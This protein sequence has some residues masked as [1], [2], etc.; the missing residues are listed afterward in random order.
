MRTRDYRRKQRAKHI[1]RKEDII[2]SY[3]LDNPPHYYE[4]KDLFENVPKIH[5]V[6]L[7]KEGYWTPYWVVNHRGKLNKGKIHCSCSMCSAKTRNKGTRRQLQGNYAPSINYKIS[8]LQKI[9]QMDWDEEN[10]EKEEEDILYDEFFDK[11][12]NW[13]KNKIS[14]NEWKKLKYGY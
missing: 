13:L 6:A 8:D 10:W 5:T 1:K 3:R 9:N 11:E 7:L 4:D 14:E 12:Y 2:R